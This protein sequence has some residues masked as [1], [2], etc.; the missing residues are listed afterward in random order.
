MLLNE[1]LYAHNM[2]SKRM[3]A[4]ILLLLL[5]ALSILPFFIEK[6]NAQ[7]TSNYWVSVNPTTDF[8]MY[9]TVGRNWTLSF[10]ALWSYGSNLGQPISN[11]TVTMQVSGS[12][13]G[14]ITTLQLNTTSGVFSFNYSSSTADMITFTPTKLVTQDNI[15]Y[16]STLLKTNGIQAYGFQSKSVTVWYDNFDVSLISSNTKTLE[17]IAVKVN[18]TYLLIPQ[19]GLTLPAKD[20]F[21]NQ[22]FLPKIVH[23]AN[24][25]INGVKAEETAIAGIYTAN[26]STVFPT[27][28]VIVAVSQNGWTTTYTAFGFTHE[29][30]AAIWEQASLIGLIF[31]AVLLALS[32][33]LFRKSIRATSLSGR[34]SFPFIGGV[35]LMLTSIVSLYWGA[36]AVEAT[37]HGFAWLLLAVL[38]L[39]SFVLG[40][41]GSVLS[42]MKKNQTIVIFT[43]GAP[44]IAN[45]VAV[46][47]LLDTYQ[48][49]GPW[50]AIYLSMAISIVSTV[51]I[52]NSD[53]YFSQPTQLLIK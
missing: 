5:I 16:N 52:C 8:Q 47:F 33:V 22:T 9:T 42:M 40:L 19:E 26:V 3:P 41:A 13:S 24:V 17:A 34:G 28:Y 29:A 12:K 32:L 45:I 50:L 1:R 30:N 4:R 18:I 10:Q 2:H 49:P 38:G 6:A 46:K 43:I 21:S 44:V 20:T 36:V 15:E 51:L 53:E 39:S 35:L 7:T 27:A 25:T 11:A 48:L 37:L 31:V 14:K 23:G